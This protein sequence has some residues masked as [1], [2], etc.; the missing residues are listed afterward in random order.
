MKKKNL[1][2]AGAAALMLAGAGAGI[3]NAEPFNQGPQ[4][5]QFQQQNNY[6][7]QLQDAKNNANNLINALVFMPQPLK[8]YWHGRVNNASTVEE[9]NSLGSQA[10]QQDA[11][12]GN[13]FP[14]AASG[15]SSS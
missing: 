4:Q 6:A 2:A 3:A 8:D 15:S 12:I 10:W 11:Q 13:F 14:G 7:Q 5:Q 9:A 1:F